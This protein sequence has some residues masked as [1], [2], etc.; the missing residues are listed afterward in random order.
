[1]AFTV[2]IL[3]AGEFRQEGH[4]GHEVLKESLHVPHVTP[5]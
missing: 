2:E 3:K 5:V 4:E 1:M